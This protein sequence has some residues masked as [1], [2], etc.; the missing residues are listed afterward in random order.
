[1]TI[2][3][4]K[5]TV[6]TYEPTQIRS[7]HCNSFRHMATRIAETGANYDFSALDEPPQVA[8]LLESGW[9]IKRLRSPLQGETRGGA[10]VEDQIMKEKRK[11]LFDGCSTVYIFWRHVILYYARGGCTASSQ[12]D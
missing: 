8:G 11:V 7:G 1:M 5:I 9:T 2:V 4:I 12:V 3:N 6:D 10:H